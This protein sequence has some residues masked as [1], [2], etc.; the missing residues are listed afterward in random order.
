MM[1]AEESGERGEGVFTKSQAE[2]ARPLSSTRPTAGRGR[3]GVANK[4]G[5][6]GIV[7]RG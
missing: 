3:T 5:R 2:R 4:R 1:A 7:R 6:G